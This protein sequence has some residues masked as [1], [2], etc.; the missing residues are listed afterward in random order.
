MNLD[1]VKLPR[2][3]LL[4]WA[5][6]A[7]VATRGGSLTSASGKIPRRRAAL[8]QN[9]LFAGDYADPSILRVGGD[10]Y[11]TH[12][13]YRYAPGLVIWHSRDLVNWTPLSSALSH[14]YER[15]EVWG[16]RSRRTPG[17]VFHL[18]SD[19][20]HFCRPCGTPARTVERTD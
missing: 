12:T 17:A 14:S 3:A 4:Q 19:G 9:P 18:F 7:S 16:A 5:V 8:F 11:I 20:R 10:F 1:T 15:A 6:G 2:R 13:S